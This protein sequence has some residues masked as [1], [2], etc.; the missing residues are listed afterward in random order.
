MSGYEDYVINKP[1]GFRLVS[2]EV[3][4]KAK[5]HHT[6]ISALKKGNMTVKEIHEV[7]KL[8]DGKY[9]KTLKTVYRHLDLLEQI[10]LIMV[11]GHRKYEGARSLE[12]LYCR[13]AKVF[14]DLGSKQE[15]WLDTDDGK[16]LLD[17]ITEVLW[18]TNDGHGDKPELRRLIEKFSREYM[19]NT[20][21]IIKNMSSDNKFE[22]LV[23]SL[24]FDHIRSLLEI[25][26][27]VQTM[28]ENKEIYEGI[29]EKLF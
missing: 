1:E 4:S 7:H 5:E 15:E 10:D 17:S 9:S 21:E 8:P 3:F 28:L 20:V 23:D 29:R 12:K 14:T 6:I 19:K 25:V 2:D 16:I 26:P 13:T 22:N 18:L 24:G 11:A 27:L